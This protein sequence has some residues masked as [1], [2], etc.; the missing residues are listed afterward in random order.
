MIYITPI[1]IFAAILSVLVLVKL[2]IFFIKPS[3]MIKIAKELYE[4]TALMT[5]VYLL[6][7]IIVGYY[8]F[9][10]FS[11]VQVSALLLFASILVGIG[12]IPYTKEFIGM[13]EKESESRA[14]FL[15]KN[16]PSI[17]I[18]GAIAFWTLYK[19]FLYSK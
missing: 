9:A 13:I 17:L 19:V 5:A 7:A 11:I 12:L 2:L 18:W 14:T 8:I 3:A 15:M 16:W 6:L 4:K 10:S 1:E